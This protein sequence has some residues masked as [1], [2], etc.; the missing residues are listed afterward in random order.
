MLSDRLFVEWFGILCCCFRCWLR[1][2]SLPRAEVRV[3][4]MVLSIRSSRG[5]RSSILDRRSIRMLRTDGLRIV[6]ARFRSLFG[7]FRSRV[8]AAVGSGRGWVV[9][10]NSW[11]LLS[12]WG[13]IW[14]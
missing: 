10:P 6:P 7:A 12:G 13:R 3:C 9:W 5:C 1:I 4:R 14:S 11:A 8:G 2:L